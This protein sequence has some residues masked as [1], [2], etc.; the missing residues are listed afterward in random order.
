MTLAQEMF[1]FRDQLAQKGIIFC[2]SGYMTEDILTGIGKAIRTKLEYEKTDKKTARGVFSVFVEQV[3]NVIR[4]SAEI[5]EDLSA[6][7]RQQLRYG[8]IAVGRKEEDY[9]VT[10]SN[11]IKA[12]DVHRLNT[13]LS[14][15]QKLDD[16]GLK[17][18][19]KEILKG[20]TPEGSKG[21]GVGFVDIARRASNGFEFD[22]LSI[23]AERSYFSLKAYV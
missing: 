4:Y 3:Q 5:D 15:I 20:D 23:D 14:E 17:K 21:A 13:N 22:F 9:F 11:L 2:Y 10:C 19:Y 1:E 18:L 12:D 7:D 6:E 16:E 8:V